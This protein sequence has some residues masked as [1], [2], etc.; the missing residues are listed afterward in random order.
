M[1]T[2]RAI[3]RLSLILVV[4][5]VLTVIWMG[6]IPFLGKAG[7]RKQVLVNQKC[8][9]GIGLLV[10]HNNFLIPGELGVICESRR[11]QQHIVAEIIHV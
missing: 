5:G 9:G 1:R 2:I 3:Y 11:A 6:R 10:L 8:I 4:T 7:R